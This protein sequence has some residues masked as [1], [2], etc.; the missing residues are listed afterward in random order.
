M[1]C[2]FC[3][4]AVCACCA[5]ALCTSA[6]GCGELLLRSSDVR[7]NGDARYCCICDAPVGT[8]ALTNL[9]HRLETELRV[10]ED[11]LRTGPSVPC[12]CR[13]WRVQGLSGWGLL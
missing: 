7:T 9:I 10:L 12:T 5:V 6:E 11:E 4:D 2:C 13:D 8:D 1:W 3:V